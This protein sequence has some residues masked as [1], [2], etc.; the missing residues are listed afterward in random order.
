MTIDDPDKQGEKMDIDV[1]VG[2]W[3]WACAVALECWGDDKDGTCAR[4]L[5]GA[6]ADEEL[7]SQVDVARRGVVKARLALA[8]ERIE[9]IKNT[10]YCTKVIR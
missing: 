9:A 7:K 6:P 4:Y 1:P 8:V 2:V 10:T 5:S 3:C